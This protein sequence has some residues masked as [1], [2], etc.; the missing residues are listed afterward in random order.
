[1]AAERETP[2]SLYFKSTAAVF[3]RNELKIECGEDYENAKNRLFAVLGKLGR[4]ILE[5]CLWHRISSSPFQNMC[6]IMVRAFH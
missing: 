3:W 1:M 4:A 6:L 2:I 5:T